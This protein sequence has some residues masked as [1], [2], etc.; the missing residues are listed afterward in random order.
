MAVVC[1]GDGALRLMLTAVA[2]MQ[3]VVWVEMG[4]PVVCAGGASLGLPLFC[5]VALLS[6]SPRHRCAVRPAVFAAGH[7]RAPDRKRHHHHHHQRKG[8]QEHHT[9]A[10]SAAGLLLRPMVLPL[11]PVTPFSP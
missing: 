3:I 4:V 8:H 2:L 7:K 5:L 10:F 11:P 1:D 9:P 6:C